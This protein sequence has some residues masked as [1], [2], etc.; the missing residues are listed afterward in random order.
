MRK[1]LHKCL[2]TCAYLFVVL[3]QFC[4]PAQ[5]AAGKDYVLGPGDVVKITLFEHADMTTEARLS[6]SGKIRFPLIG[7]VALGGLSVSQAEEQIAEQLKSGR[8]VLKPQVNLLVTQFR[9]QQV[10][11]LGHVNRPGRFPIEGPT[12]LSDVVAIAGGI[13][14]LGG[15]IITLTRTQGGKVQRKEINQVEAFQ[16]GESALDMPIQN[17][18]VVFVGRA[19]QAYVHGEVQRPG[20]FRVEAEM[21]VMQALSLGG[22]VTAK[23]SESDI[24]LTRRDAK[25]AL[26]TTTVK[27]ADRVRPDDVIYVNQAQFYIYGEVQRPGAF[28][29]EPNMTLMQALALGGGLTPR[30]TDRG[31]RLTRREANGKSEAIDAKPDDLIRSDDVIYVKERLF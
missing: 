25:G 26:V 15:D 12:R 18:D 1:A 13:G 3:T 17:G 9:G 11:V 2:L 21:T 16:S 7:E 22:G 10:S 30:G 5:G 4:V 29:V 19:P 28:R 27:P 31:I 24:K 20:S 23:G 6:E 8:F 14:P